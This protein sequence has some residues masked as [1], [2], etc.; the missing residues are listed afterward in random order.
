[1]AEGSG[2]Q[3]GTRK[4]EGGPTVSPTSPPWLGSR[5]AQGTPAAQAAE[6][7][8]SSQ[9]PCAGG[10]E[11]CGLEDPH[12]TVTKQGVNPGAG[13]CPLP[14]CSPKPLAEYACALAL[15]PPPQGKAMTSRPDTT[16]PSTHVPLEGLRNMRRRVVTGE[17]CLGCVLCQSWGC[18]WSP[19]G[20]HPWVSHQTTSS[21]GA[22][23]V[24]TISPRAACGKH[25]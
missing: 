12:Q 14:C 10:A 20:K 22:C 21:P 25:S 7:A 24:L 11:P 19:A 23:R 6:A 5:D 8:L 1:M 2:M 13:W 15:V 16:T 3:V 18:R 9:Q 4:R 17:G